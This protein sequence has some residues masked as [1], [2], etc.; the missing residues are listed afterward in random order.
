MRTVIYCYLFSS[1]N[2]YFA[3]LR[4]ISNL[5]AFHFEQK[6]KDPK[7]LEFQINMLKR[8]VFAIDYTCAC[9]CGRYYSSSH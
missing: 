9:P 3:E 5:F 2:V 1:D 7:L 4:M 6:K 8:W